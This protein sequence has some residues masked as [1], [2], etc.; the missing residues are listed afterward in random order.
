MKSDYKITDNPIDTLTFYNRTRLSKLY[1]LA[2]VDIAKKEAPG[3]IFKM[4]RYPIP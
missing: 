2:P 4:R 3:F 1:N